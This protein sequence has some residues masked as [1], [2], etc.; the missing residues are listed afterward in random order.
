M[1]VLTLAELQAH[2]GGQ[3]KGDATVSIR[4]AASLEKA[5]PNQIGFLVSA[6]YLDQART[7]R[8]GALIVPENLEG[9]LPQPSLL[10]A[11]PHAAFA[12]ATALLHPE[13]ELPI[14]IDPSAV[15]AKDAEIDPGARIGPGAVIG[16]DTRIGPRSV[17]HAS[18]VIG[19]GVS[20]G[21]DC[22][23]HPRVTVQHG[24]VVGN[25]VI[26]HPGCVIG[27]DGF[28]L[29]W[30]KDAAGG[31][32]SKVPQVG[33]VILEDDVEVGANT[34][35]DRG[36]LDDTV[37]EQGAKLDNLIQIAHNCRVGRHTAIAACVGIAGSTKIGAFCQIGGA[38]MIIGHLEI[39]DRVTVSAGTFVAKD[40]REPGT[41]TSVQP[42]MRHEDWLKN[43]A[44][45]RHLDKL[46]TRVKALEK[47]LKKDEHND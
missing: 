14:G 32:W 47:L 15:V 9:V 7:S 31:H 22:L 24:C 30:E 5:G 38:A 42:Q 33:R 10:V 6:K 1:P 16:S 2:L 44:H 19:P 26:L 37:I 35:I 12:R 29:A 36:A 45:L 43:V 41:Y 20:L 21:E 13:P 11:N 34:T 18:C 25:R 39:C 27:G 8:A 3:L 40:I 46:A 28:G 4:G 23:L 17:V